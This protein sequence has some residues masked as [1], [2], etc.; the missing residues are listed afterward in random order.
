MEW[1]QPKTIVEL[2]TFRGYSTSWLILGTLLN[3]A[4]H[5]HAF[6][7]FKEGYY[8]DMWYDRFG[9][10]KKD[11]FYHEIPGG[12]WNFASEVPEKIDLIFHDTDHNA[13][14][15]EKEM[16][17]LIPRLS[18]GGLILID[19]MLHSQYLPMQRFFHGLFGSWSLDW[20]WSVLPVGHGL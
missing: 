3:Q 19:D 11:F 4:G 10:P 6:E 7:V 1:K 14:P 9:L 8:G 20:K 17:L 5:V 2:G 18:V 16:A 12:I 15:S 13:G